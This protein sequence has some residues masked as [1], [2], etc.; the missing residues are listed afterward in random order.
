MQVGSLL[1]ALAVYA[2]ALYALALCALVLCALALCALTAWVGR[3][4][5]VLVALCVRG[6]SEV[7]LWRLTSFGQGGVAIGAGG[8]LPGRR[9]P[10]AGTA[11][12]E[13]QSH[14]RRLIRRLIRPGRKW[15]FD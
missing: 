3:R 14:V 15:F 1:D 12:G 6:V 7:W 4:I 9:A 13:F 5:L 2:L 8:M 11:R 10:N